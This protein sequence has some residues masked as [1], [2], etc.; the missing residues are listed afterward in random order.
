MLVSIILPVKNEGPNIKNTLYSAL[1]VKTNCPFEIIVV[2][3]NST[4]GCCD[5]L[6]GTHLLKSEY[7]SETGMS[8]TN[9]E[10]HPLKLE[11]SIKLITTKGVGAAQAR[12]I[13]AEAS[14][15]KYLIFCD[16]HLFFEDYWIDNLIAPI[17]KGTAHA[18]TPGIASTDNPYAIGFGQSLKNDL[19]IRWYGW[20]AKPFE[21]AVLPGGCFVIGRETFFAIDGFDRG[22]KIWGY[23]DIEISIKL[24]LFGY[25]CMVEP[26]VTILHLFREAH[27]YSVSY[28]HIDYNMLR[29]AYS[30]FNEERIEKTKKLIK[31]STLPDLLKQLDESDTFQQR[32]KYLA[33]RKY[34]DNWYM[35]KFQ[36]PF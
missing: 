25:T 3:D 32:K 8:P 1:Q 19:T 20:K 12:N 35:E 18:I 7:S 31:Y 13:G 24:W 15:G 28:K 11:S 26:K 6:R 17:I 21:I 30:H 14:K 4:D 23:E 22:F 5:F 2:D 33:H 36:I 9:Q 34:D 29:M 16:A 10:T 27:P